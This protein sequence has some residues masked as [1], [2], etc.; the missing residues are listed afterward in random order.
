MLK[1]IILK[2]ENKFIPSSDEKVIHALKEH[3][4][5]SGLSMYLLSY[6]TGITSGGSFSNLIK[7][8]IMNR[9]LDKSDCPCCKSAYVYRLVK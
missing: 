8:M 3:G 7:G 1:K 2:S 4:K 6:Y 9:I 5:K